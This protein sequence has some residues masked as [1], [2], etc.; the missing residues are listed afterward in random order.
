[1]FPF[2]SLV[3]RHESSHYSPAAEFLPDSLQRQPSILDPGLSQVFRTVGTGGMSLD[4]GETSAVER[5]VRLGLSAN[6]HADLIL[7]AVFLEME[8]L[9]STET[10]GF[11][12]RALTSVADTLYYSCS[13]LTRIICV[14]RPTIGYM[15]HSDL[16]RHST[17]L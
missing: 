12:T 6:P 5:L 3:V 16:E 9:R 11:I 13:A 4:T 15:Y 17:F 2:Y 8:H 7:S 14:F 10:R 1:M